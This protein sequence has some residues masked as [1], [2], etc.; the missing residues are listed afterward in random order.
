MTSYNFFKG[1]GAPASSAWGYGLTEAPEGIKGEMNDLSF[2][3]Y[4]SH[5]SPNCKG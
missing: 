5:P 4:Y 2:I 3:F 1:E